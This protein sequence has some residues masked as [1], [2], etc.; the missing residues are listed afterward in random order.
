MCDTEHMFAC[1]QAKQQVPIDIFDL[2][3]SRKNITILNRHF[4]LKTKILQDDGGL[5]FLGGFPAVEE[6]KVRFYSNSFIG[7]NL[8]DSNNTIDP[9]ILTNT[10]LKDAKD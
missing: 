1:P 4:L 10:V 5:S 6:V 8:Q 2:F 9:K 7:S 3:R